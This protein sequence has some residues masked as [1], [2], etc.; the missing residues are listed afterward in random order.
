MVHCFTEMFEL[1]RVLM[2]CIKVTC[3][4]EEEIVYCVV[5]EKCDPHGS[6]GPPPPQHL[7]ILNDLP[8]GGG[9]GELEGMEFFLEPHIY[10]I[11]DLMPL[12]TDLS[13]FRCC[14]IMSH[15]VL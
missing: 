10:W 3:C 15:S 12:C 5:T 14:T 6:S 9:G 2:T 1:L 7:I 11:T 4:R 8:G 13:N